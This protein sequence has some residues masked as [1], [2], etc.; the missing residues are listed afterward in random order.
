MTTEDDARA[1]SGAHLDEEQVVDIGV[2]RSGF[3]ETKQIGVVVDEGRAAECLGQLPRHRIAVPAGHD[4]R[5]D[6]APGLE[7]DRTGQTHSHP[8]EPRPV[9]THIP[10]QVAKTPDDDLQHDRGGLLDDQFLGAL[11]KQVAAR[12]GQREPGVRRAEIGGE[13]ELVRLLE[14]Q[15]LRG[16][17]GGAEPL[18]D[19]PDIARGRALVESRRDRRAGKAGEP[20]EITARL[21]PS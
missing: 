8:G 7:V 9:P 5:L 3:P 2:A 6:R 17:A 16:P 18:L 11:G 1:D 21:H 14:R 13:N 10:E 4:R 12:V 15:E 19:R 20:L